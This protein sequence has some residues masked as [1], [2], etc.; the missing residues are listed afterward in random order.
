MFDVRA[1]FAALLPG[2]APRN[3]YER[4]VLALDSGRHEHALSEFDRALAESGSA[5]AAAATHNKRGVAFIALGLPDAA[6]EAFSSAL[7]HDARHA[8]AL[9][10]IGN[11]LLEDGHV[12][13]AID[14]YEAAIRM[15]ERYPVAYRNLGVA[16][17]RLGR[18]AEA[19]R[20]L[21]AAARLEGRRRPGRG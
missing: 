18:Q 11:L 6:L 2:R 14:Y 5:G 21:R 8:P 17:K 1:V 13:D 15:D 7:E 9:A 4:G 10:N 16:Y 12:L 19:V 3:A 20:A